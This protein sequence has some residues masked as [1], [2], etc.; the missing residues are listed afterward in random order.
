MESDLPKVLHE[1]AGQPLL[2]H[3]LATARQLSPSRIC[4]VIGH[5]AEAIQQRFADSPDVRWALQSEQLGTGHAVRCALPELDPDQPTLVLYGDVPLISVETLR[6]LLSQAGSD[7]LALLTVEF[8]DPTGYGRIIRQGGRIVKILEQK[9]TQTDAE[10]AIREIN[11]GILVAPTR[12]LIGWLAALSNAN[13]QREY[14]LTDIVASAV[15]DGVEVVAAQPASTIEALGVNSKSQ[16]ED[17][18]CI[19]SAQK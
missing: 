10:R 15:A 8:D 5:G 1:L 2:A 13:S 19:L 9:D 14:Y 4:V 18:E 17:L 12:R 7:R 16:L 6:G 11:T 3:V